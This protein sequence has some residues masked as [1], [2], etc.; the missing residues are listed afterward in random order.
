MSDWWQFDCPSSARKWRYRDDGF[1]ELDDGSIPMYPR[2][3]ESVNQYR[4]QIE[5]A[6][7]KWD[8]PP[9]WIAATM[10]RETGGRSVC[11]PGKHG[12]TGPNCRHAGGVCEGVCSS[13]SGAEG[14]GLM[15]VMPRP[16]VTCLDM[17]SDPAVAID[18]GCW[19][20]DQCRRLLGDH[21]GNEYLHLALCHNAWLRKRPDGSWYNKCGR[22]SYKGQTC[23]D[24]QQW[25]VVVGCIKYGSDLG[26]RCAPAEGG[27][28]VCST[29]YAQTAVEFHN[30]ALVGFLG[31]QDPTAPAPPDNGTEPVLTATLDQPALPVI[32]LLLGAAVGY[33]GWSLVR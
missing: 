8:F 24:P 19:A 3:P 7:A 30:A 29:E 10:A 33:I 23:P 20:M 15:A 22:G 9:E 14:C 16:D 27:G 31:L 1:I 28:Y 6:A 32:A 17:M 13:C 12:C 4:Q 21:Y 11:L 2:W 26:P 5:E 18:R 25:G